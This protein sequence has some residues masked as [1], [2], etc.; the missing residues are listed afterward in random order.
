M[1]VA[2]V[3][4]AAESTPP[5]IQTLLTAESADDIPDSYADEHRKDSAL[6][7]IFNILL[8]EELSAED[9][10]ARKIAL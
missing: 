7:K 10:L 2:T 8:K 4:I 1:Q 3:T 6:L 9:K 5:T